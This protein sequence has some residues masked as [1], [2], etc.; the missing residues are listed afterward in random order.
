MNM[1][2]SKAGRKLQKLFPLEKNMRWSVS[3]SLYFWH[4]KTSEKQKYEHIQVK[5]VHE[6][7]LKVSKS[8]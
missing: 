1:T 4:L 2:S 7:F 6:S 5:D 3:H 8:K